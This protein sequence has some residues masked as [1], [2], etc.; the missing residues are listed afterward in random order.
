VRN[1]IVAAIFLLL[2][3][4][5]D[6]KM[7]F[8]KK[9]APVKATDCLPQILI[10]VIPDRRSGRYRAYIG[11]ET[12]P[13]CVSRQPFLDG[14]R[15]LLA[16]G[17]DGRTVLVMRWVG[18]EDWALRGPL[19]A[20]AKLTVDEHNGTFAKWKPY[21]RSAVPPGSANTARTVPNGRAAIKLIPEST[22]E[23]GQRTEPPGSSRLA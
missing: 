21:S 2:R 3:L 1:S 14:A 11:N 9:P 13:L 15:K 7:E 19:R 6:L 16:R 18:A 5:T 17:H 12:K 8:D 20:A 10:T 23:K 22:A 4:S